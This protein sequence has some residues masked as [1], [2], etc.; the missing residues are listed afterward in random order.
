MA[1]WVDQTGLTRFWQKVKEKFVLKE[2]GK[3]L[4]ANDFTAAYKSKLDGIAAG[5]NKYAHPTTSGNKH[6]PSG[7]SAGQFLKWSADG[8]A[9][10]AVDNNTTYGVMRGAT[11]SAAGTSG[12]TPVPTAG[13]ANRY[14]RSD[15]TWV[16]PPDT[17]TTYGLATQ[18][19]NGLQSAADKKKLDGISTGAN[20]Y[21]HPSVHSASMINV[22][23]GSSTVALSDV[24][25]CAVF[26]IANDDN[27]ITLGNITEWLA[28]GKPKL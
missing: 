2:S 8:T 3:G 28:A 21:V 18:T 20:N 12:L 26:L 17:N 11:T 15:G 25:G 23:I 9:V 7:G 4:S 10:W 24:I 13:A 14:L 27:A 19:A 16:V 1:K 6:I 5:A 22:T